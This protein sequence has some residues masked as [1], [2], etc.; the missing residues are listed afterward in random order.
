MRPHRQ[1]RDFLYAKSTLDSRGGRLSLSLFRITTRVSIKKPASRTRPV[2]NF[3]LGKRCFALA[4]FFSVAFALKKSQ[5]LSYHFFHR[6]IPLD[7]HS[8][9]YSESRRQMSADENLGKC[10]CDMRGI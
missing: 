7:V 10:E 9:I 5:V 2:D 3:C 8:A 6:E 1:E 4:H